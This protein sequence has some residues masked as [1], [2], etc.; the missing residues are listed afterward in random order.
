MFFGCYFDLSE[1]ETQ[2]K[3][4]LMNLRDRASLITLKSKLDEYNKEIIYQK[5]KRKITIKNERLRSQQ[6]VQIANFLYLN[7]LDYEYEKVILIKL[8][9]LESYTHLISMLS[10]ET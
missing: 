1:S 3:E 8:K 9:A 2:N 10:K 4:E 5:S 6:E 7:G